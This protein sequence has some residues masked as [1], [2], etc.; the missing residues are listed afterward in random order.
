MS[1]ENKHSSE[2]GMNTKDTYNKPEK[3][4]K[5]TQAALTEEKTDGE[6]AAVPAGISLA[7]RQ[8]KL[9][10]L[11]EVERL[12]AELLD[13]A[14]NP[15]PTKKTNKVQKTVVP[16]PTVESPNMAEL[17][18][19]AGTIAAA[20]L[21]V[22][23][24]QAEVMAESP[25]ANDAPVSAE[26][27]DAQAPQE[28]ETTET[29]KNTENE[30]VEESADGET[31]LLTK[32]E[33]EPAAKSEKVEE[34]ENAKKSDTPQKSRPF[35]PQNTK[36]IVLTAVLSVVGLALLLVGIE[37]V[38]LMNIFNSVNYVKS[39]NPFADTEMMVSES[40]IAKYVSHSDETKNILLVGYDVD[41]NDISRSDSMII[42]TIDH[43]HQKIKMTS[44]MRDMYVY[45]P[46][47]GRH[48]LNAAFV[49]GGPE[50]L[51]ETIYANFGLPIDNYVCVDYAAFVDVVDYIGGVQVDIEEIELEQFN[52]YVRG[53]KKNKIDEAGSYVFNGQQT[54][55][56]CRIRKVGSDTAR[57]ARQRE[58]LGKIMKRCSRL[59]LLKLENLLRITAPAVTT[60]LTQA[61]IFQLAAEGLDSMNYDMQ[62]MRIPVDGAWW[63][64]QINGTWYVALDLNTNAR[65]LHDFI[66]GDN[67]TSDT[68]AANL[69]ESDSAAEEREREN[70]E[71][72]KALENRE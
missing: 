43:E 56:Y 37:A 53:G 62:G 55:S 64:E 8:V 69:A 39:A 19:A 16:E 4:Q 12:T 48:K 24:E 35:L 2:P 52:K 44:L 31:A 23:L 51:L 13:E 70:F 46:G 50:L 6:S 17:A 14:K 71:R 47:H 42:L 59:S 25:A 21:S 10:A 40:V 57:T 36:R 45:I 27:K 54:L 58:V 7:S 68:L 63:D 33:T 20:E 18:I 66:Y 67:E 1:K 5:E 9:E 49:Y 30:P 38:R 15:A 61:E 32:N 3:N 22:P 41:E 28:A 11:P 34:P 29:E 65:Y 26:K 72:K 60:N